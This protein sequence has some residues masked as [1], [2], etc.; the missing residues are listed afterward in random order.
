MKAVIAIGA[1]WLLAALLPLQA[2]DPKDD[3]KDTKD[4]PP[5]RTP[6]ESLLSKNKELIPALINILGDADSDM[7]QSAHYLLGTIGQIDLQHRIRIPE[8]EP[9]LGTI[10]KEVI[11]A[12][13]D[14]LKDKN[15]DRR[16]NAAYVLGQFG[17]FAQDAMP[18]LVVA[19]KDEE[20]EVRKRVIFAINRIL[21]DTAT[22]ARP[23]ASASPASSGIVPAGYTAPASRPGVTDPGLLVPAGAPPTPMTAISPACSPPNPPPS[24]YPTAPT[25]PR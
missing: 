13:I 11:T 10:G 12:L 6:I 1:G 4:K 23:A 18:A 3:K 5:P 7:R 9:N 16:A 22:P 25:A 17:K 8:P 14:T 2:A 24:L 20:L 21:E 19:L 15:R